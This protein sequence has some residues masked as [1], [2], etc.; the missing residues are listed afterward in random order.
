M[1]FF[2]GYDTTASAI[3]FLMYLLAVNPEV[4]DKLHRKII[5]VSKDKVLYIAD[6]KGHWFFFSSGGSRSLSSGAP[7]NC[8]K[9]KKIGLGGG[10]RPLWPPLTSTTVLERASAS[11]VLD[12]F[13]DASSGSSGGS[14]IS[15]RRGRQL[16]GG[17]P[18][19]DFIKI[20]RK[21]HEIKENSRPLRPP[22][23]SATGLTCCITCTKIRNTHI[24]CFIRTK[25]LW[26]SGFA[27]FPNKNLKYFMGKIMRSL[28]HL[29]LLAI[30]LRNKLGTCASPTIMTSYGLY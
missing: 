15:P 17:A 14:R 30:K 24:Y 5:N 20:S 23:R 29:G 8:M 19:Y 25:T 18:G 26:Y 7:K 21:L 4:Q 1:F 2:G 3:S 10:V 28:S 16:S 11:H 12:F 6:K 9:L 13:G 27:E 22:L